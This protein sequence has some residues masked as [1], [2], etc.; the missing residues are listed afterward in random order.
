MCVIAVKTKGVDFAPASAIRRCIATNPD[1]FAMA[2]NQDGEIRVYKTMDPEKALAKYEEL[3][4]GLDPKT[5]AMVF[6]ARIATHGSKGI[7][8]CHCWDHDGR[9]AFAHNGI[10]RNIGNH[11]D[12]TDSET[13]FRDYFVP[14]LDGVGMEYAM[15]IARLVAEPSGSKFAFLSPDGEIWMVGYWQKAEFKDRKGKVYFS[16]SSYIEY[17]TYGCA[18]QA[19][20]GYS[21]KLYESEKKAYGEI[22]KKAFAPAPKPS[23][24]KAMSK[25]DALYVR[26]ASDGRAIVAEPFTIA[27]LFGK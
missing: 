25:N 10:L 26:R 16:N 2:W 1:G 27:S 9:I 13:F 6:H 18:S 22:F 17:N 5:T 4:S 12:Q 3:A 21:S 23:K 14:A 20:D 11:D 7:A 24:K 8:N 15:R 19:A